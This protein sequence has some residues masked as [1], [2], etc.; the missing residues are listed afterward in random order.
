MF[1]NFFSYAFFLLTPLILPGADSSGNLVPSVDAKCQNI[2]TGPD[3]PV[4]PTGPTGPTGSQGSFGPD[5]NI[6]PQGPTGP[7]GTQGIVGP[8]GAV[9]PLGSTGPTG[10]QGPVGP[11]GNIGPAGATGATGLTGATGPTGLTGPTG[12]T[13]GTGATGATGL[14]SAFGYFANP[15]IQAVAISGT[16]DLTEMLK[17]SGG[18]ALSNN[19]VLI[20]AT[21]DY[22]VQYE[23]L[24]ATAN[25]S[26]VL[27]GSLSGVFQSSV[28][29][30]VG[31]DTNLTG[32]AL[33]SL[34]GG[35]TL[36]I[37]NNLTGAFNTS[38]STGA[39]F[40]TSPVSLTIMR[41]Q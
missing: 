15:G 23:I 36:T 3:G 13:G 38:Q 34:I 5:G 26:V 2:C 35:E 21:G 24:T 37:V 1:K 11:D 14:T 20:P 22:L 30:L 4:G 9:G 6:G 18:F 8:E 41:M 17:G 39:I 16:V 31:V 25:V 27:V 32:M 33:L 40:P 19:G 29:G 12:A 28:Y 7:T 10:A